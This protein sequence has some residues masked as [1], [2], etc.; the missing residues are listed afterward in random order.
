AD[1]QA[2][3]SDGK[4]IA[5]SRVTI[6]DG[7][8][9]ADNALTA[10][11]ITYEGVRITDAA[12]TATSEASSV[13]LS[14][15][16]LGETAQNS[17]IAALLG[18]FDGLV[19]SS[20]T[21]QSESGEAI[22]VGT[23]SLLVAA[24]ER[25]GVEAGTITM[26]DLVIGPELLDPPTA[27]R[28]NSLGYDGLTI[29][30]SAAGEWEA[31]TG[32]AV[33]ERSRLA[34]AGMGALELEASATGLTQE[35]YRTLS[36]GGVDFAALLEV[37]GTISIQNLTVGF[38]DDGL[39]DRLIEAG[40]QESG[41]ER[42]ALIERIVGTMSGPLAALGDA[43]FAEMVTGHA[44]AFLAQ[45]GRIAVRARPASAVTAL[46]VISAA[47]LNPQLLPELLA[48]EIERQ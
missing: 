9:D 33:L 1:I 46:Q 42:G 24:P 36:A 43:S 16:R 20:L 4:A 26:E 15:P 12:G 40:A 22:S 2:G 44:R 27:E 38:A 47:T 29:D 45:P 34:V 48:I 35:S 17:G 3:A 6:T 13:R 31:A 19:V 30:F 28:L 7:L 32:A 23:L 14:S 18:N 41:I 8:V 21:A 37:M 39:T 25:P 11:A 10:A 5:I